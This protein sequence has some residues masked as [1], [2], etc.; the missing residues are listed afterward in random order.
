MKIIFK[1][2]S[3]EIW[4]RDIDSK[5]EDN[6]KESLTHWKGFAILKLSLFE[7]QSPVFEGRM[8]DDCLAFTC[9]F[10]KP[11][12]CL[13]SIDFFSFSNYQGGCDKIFDGAERVRTDSLREKIYQSM[14]P[15]QKLKIALQLYSSVRQ[16]NLE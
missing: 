5:L 2:L 8:R 1:G 6:R 7:G 9:P 4:Y 13:S 14:T 11:D 12:P 3:F 16:L 15:E 10:K